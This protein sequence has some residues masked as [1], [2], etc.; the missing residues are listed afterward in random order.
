M[1]PWHDDITD[2]VEDKYA[3]IL[4]FNEPNHAN[5][6]G[7]PPEEA[8][9]WGGKEEWMTTFIIAYNWDTFNLYLGM[10]SCSRIP[11]NEKYSFYCF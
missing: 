1:R 9:A 4:G 6:A 7:I 10:E 8:A 2:I 5:Q 3:T 11:Q